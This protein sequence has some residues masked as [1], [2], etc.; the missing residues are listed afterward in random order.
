MCSVDLRER[1]YLVVCLESASHKYTKKTRRLT[2]TFL[3][4][5]RTAALRASLLSS[6]R[7]LSWQSAADVAPVI[8]VELRFQEFWE[9]IVLLEIH[10]RDGTDTQREAISMQRHHRRPQNATYNNAEG[11]NEERKRRFKRVNLSQLTR[12]EQRRWAFSALFLKT[13]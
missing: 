11:W 9:G 12:I 2:R 7:R 13:Q 6:A 4:V 1:K 8:E 3:I 5:T 10:L